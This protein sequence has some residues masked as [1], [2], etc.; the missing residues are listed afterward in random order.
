MA[1]GKRIR[2]TFALV[3]GL[4]LFGS[5]CSLRD[6]QSAQ[7]LFLGS[8]ARSDTVRADSDYAD[9]LAKEFNGLV[10]EN[11]LK[12]GV[13]HPQPGTYNFAPADALVDFAE[14][15]KM[16]VRGVPL[17][18]DAQNPAW[19]TTGTF[20]RTALFGI[21][22]DHINTVVGRYRGRIAQWDVVNEPF[23]ETGSLKP[24][25][26]R[27]GLGFSYMDQAFALARGA[28][29]AAKLFLNEFNIESPGL[30]ADAVFA[31]VQGM[32]QRGVPIDGVGFEMHANTSA[33]TAQQLAVQ[34]ARY[35]AIGVDVGITE[36][37]VKL[38]A[39][40]TP[41]ELKDQARVYREALATCRAATNCKTFVVWG[42]T[43]KYSW[44]PDLVP[45]FGAATIMDATFGHKPAYD[46][47]N[48]ELHG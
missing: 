4:G 34:M 31:A 15:H 29:P 23:S 38:P 1:R 10:P 2:A 47:L 19:L 11:E 36:L 32:R 20:S 14:A 7:S 28:D 33:P 35:A 22:A 39:T 46:A 45:G 12:W 25:L 27:R 8:A 30:K 5:A 43:D 18:W 16:S 26:W 41:D 17:L 6:Y 37:D 44:I 21:L 3:L 40:P 13:I 24:T 9:N 42:F 48:D